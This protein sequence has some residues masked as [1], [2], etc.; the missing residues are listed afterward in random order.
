MSTV[1]ILYVLQV[2]GDI[3]RLEVGDVMP[4]DGILV[5]AAEH[6]V[7]DGAIQLHL[8]TRCLYISYTVSFW[9]KL[10]KG[11]WRYIEIVIFDGS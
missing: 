2:V 5:H 9:R 4:A 10:F 11:G 6:D 1:L 8:A 7:H 3:I